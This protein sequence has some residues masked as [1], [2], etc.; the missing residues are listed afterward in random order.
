[1]LIDKKNKAKYKIYGTARCPF[2]AMATNMLERKGYEYETVTLPE[3]SELIAELKT[4]TSHRTVP[5]I[6][7]V[8]DNNTEKFIGGFDELKSQI[9]KI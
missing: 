9:C 4:S 6:F 8:G 1:M 7:E 2:C 3:G 5:L